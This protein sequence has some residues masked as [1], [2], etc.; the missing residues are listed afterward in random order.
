MFGVSIFY[1]II[2][3]IGLK[4]SYRYLKKLLIIY[5][6]IFYTDIFF[7]LNIYFKNNH[8]EVL[9]FIFDYLYDSICSI[10]SQNNKAILREVVD[11]II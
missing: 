8:I 6:F 11:N 5:V 10:K 7:Y 1:L 4:F 9:V 3:I 2:F